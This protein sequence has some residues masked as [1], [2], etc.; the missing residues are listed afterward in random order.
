[1]NTGREQVIGVANHEGVPIN[2]ERLIE[3]IDN[4]I[5]KGY[6]NE[7]IVKVIGCVPSHIDKRRSFLRNLKNQ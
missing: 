4:L 2:H 3:G 5:K 6:G 1:M 7:Q